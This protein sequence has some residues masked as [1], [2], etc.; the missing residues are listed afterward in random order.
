MERGFDEMRLIDL[1]AGEVHA[2]RVGPPARL[3]VLEG[4]VWVTEERLL[5]DIVAGRGDEIRV[6]RRGVAVLEGLDDARLAVV[7]ARRWP[8][9]LLGMLQR[10]AGRL[11]GGHGSA[12]SGRPG[13]D[14]LAACG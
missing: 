6:S 1:A 13:G 9:H 8:R 12:P 4:R 11:R 5:D 7:T 3:R 2:L 14:R 10:L